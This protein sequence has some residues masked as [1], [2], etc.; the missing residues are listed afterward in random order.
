MMNKIQ[1]SKL[2]LALFRDLISSSLGEGCSTS[3][4]S[5]MNKLRRSDLPSLTLD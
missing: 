3:H 2:L 1:L 5:V 4:Q